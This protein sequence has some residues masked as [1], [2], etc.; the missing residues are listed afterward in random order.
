M[1]ATVQVEIG[2]TVAHCT[3]YTCTSLAN[4][5]NK[6]SDLKQYFH[7]KSVS[8]FFYFCPQKVVIS[9][10]EKNWTFFFCKRPRFC[11]ANELVVL[12]IAHIR[13]NTDTVS[14]RKASFKALSMR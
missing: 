4:T 6:N 10:S 7:L 1:H 13:W 12:R 5:D 11:Y 3:S 14:M 9:I 2:P 8:D